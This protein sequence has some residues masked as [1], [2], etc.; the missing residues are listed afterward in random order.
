MATTIFLWVYLFP[1]ELSVRGINL[2]Q[3]LTK[4]GEKILQ[5]TYFG[6]N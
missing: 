2:W 5:H 6:G 1:H 3:Q 4:R